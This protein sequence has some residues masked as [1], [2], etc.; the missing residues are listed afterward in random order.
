ML[1]HRA[2]KAYSLLEVVLASGICATALVPALALLR[3]GVTLAERIDTRHLLLLHGVGKMEEHLAIVSASW[4]EGTFVGNFA[5]DGHSTIRYIVV[6]SD[7][8]ANGG[9]DGRLMNVSVTTYRDA[10]G[11]AALDAAELR[12]VMTTKIGKFTSYENKASG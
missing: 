12:N 8:S 10:D 6:Q 1:R 5:A 4:T 11:D 2:R 9:M 3:D 7:D